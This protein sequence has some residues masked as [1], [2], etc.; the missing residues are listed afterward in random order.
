MPTN[1]EIAKSLGVPVSAVLTAQSYVDRKLSGQRIV[2]S[3][4]PN[5]KK[6]WSL[7]GNDPEY[8][9]QRSAVLGRGFGY[10]TSPLHSTQ[11]YSGD[12]G[13]GVIQYDHP[14]GPSVPIAYDTEGNPVFP[15]TLSTKN[16]QRYK[17]AD[18]FNPSG[19]VPGSTVTN[20][21]IQ[22]QVFENP[23][24]SFRGNTQQP[25]FFKEVPGSFG[26]PS[27][28]VLVKSNG[29]VVRTLTPQEKKEYFIQRNLQQS[30]VIA[31]PNELE[32]LRQKIY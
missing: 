7:I 18:F 26:L 14:I 5:V 25:L 24:N 11:T 8:L 10:G 27:K 6:A 13:K 31:T 22:S 3:S 28:V 20:G 15:N 16:T 9:R 19:P 23:S 2:V 12:P 29:Q 30:R 21:N 17:G 32:E 4:D 1:E